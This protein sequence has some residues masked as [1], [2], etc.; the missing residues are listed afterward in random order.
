MASEHRLWQPLAKKNKH[1]IPVAAVWLHVFISIVLTLTGSFEK[2]L[3]Y[4]GFVL[5]LMATLTVSTS[6]FIKTRQPGSFKSPLKPIL[7]IIFLVFNTG[8]LI[9]T[10]IDRPVESLIGLGIL[11]IGGIIYLFDKPRT[12]I[13]TPAESV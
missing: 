13:D 10:L 2:V 9:F 4:A 1:G 7:Q 5:Q 6:L 8:V 12:D 11:G 3:L